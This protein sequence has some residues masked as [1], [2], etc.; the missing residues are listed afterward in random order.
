MNLFKKIFNKHHLKLMSKKG[1]YNKWH[2]FKYHK[3]THYSVLLFYLVIIVK[4]FLV[5]GIAYP[6]INPEEIKAA[7]ED[8]TT[9]TEN[10]P[11]SILT[12]T[13]NSIVRGGDGIAYVYKDYG[14]DYFGDLTHQFDSYV[15]NAN[16]TSLHV[17]WGLSNLPDG[18]ASVGLFWNVQAGDS[19][20]YLNLY[21]SSCSTMGTHE[22][23]LSSPGRRY[24]KVERSGA[25]ISVFV[26]T[27]AG[28]TS[29]EDTL[30]ANCAATTYRYL[31]AVNTS[32]GA[33]DYLDV[34]NLD[35]NP[36]TPP[37]APTIQAPEATANDA[38]SWKFTDNA[39]NEDGFRV[40]DAD[41]TLLV[42]CASA[43]LD[44]CDETGLSTNTQYTGRYVVAYNGVGESAHSGTAADTYTLANPPNNA[45]VASRTTASITWNWEVNAN[46][47]G[48]EFYASDETGNS[49]WVANATSWASA[50]ASVNTQYNLSAKARN[51]DHIDTAVIN[52]AAYTAI[53]APVSLSLSNVTQNSI[54][55]TVQ[56]S[57]SHLGVG[58]SA[59]RYCNTTTSVCSLWQT[60]TANY[61]FSS[62]LAN[63]EYNFSVE[64]RNGDGISGGTAT[65][66]TYTLI[67]APDSLTASD[68]THNSITLSVGG[69]FSNLLSGSSGLRYCNI[70][71]GGCSSWQ[72]TTANYTFSSLVADT[73][74]NFSVESR[75]FNAVSGGVATISA[76]TDANPLP[77]PPQ[78]ECKLGNISQVSVTPNVFSLSSNQTQ[79]VGV[80]FKDVHG[81]PVARD[82]VE[83]FNI[84]SD[85]DDSFWN[86]EAGGGTLSFENK[87]AL[88]IL[89]TAGN[90]PG[91]FQNTIVFS[92]C[93]GQ[94]KS[95]ATPTIIRHNS[96]RVSIDPSS[97]A[98]APFESYNFKANISASLGNENDLVCRYRWDV[99]DSTAG[100]FN[101]KIKQ[102]ISFT[103][104]D[105]IGEYKISVTVNCGGG[106]HDDDT[107]NIA[108]V[109]LDQISWRLSPAWFKLNASSGQTIA[110]KMT[111][112]VKP[113]NSNTW[114]YR[115]AKV[116]YNVLNSKA[117][118]VVNAHPTLLDT[119]YFK[120]ALPGCYPFVIKGSLAP[121][122]QVYA[123]LSLNVGSGD[124]NSSYY[125]YNPGLG[126]SILYS[127][128]LIKSSKEQTLTLQRRDKNGDF[129]SWYNWIYGSSGTDYMSTTWILND[130]RIGT[131]TSNYNSAYLNLS[132]SEVGYYKKAL[133]TI[134][135]FKGERK[136]ENWDLWIEPENGKKTYSFSSTVPK[137]VK[138]PP[139][140]LF[141]GIWQGYFTNFNEFASFGYKI[142]KINNE[143]LELASPLSASGYTGDLIFR[144]KART[145]YFKNAII[146]QSIFNSSYTKAIDVQID[147]GVEVDFCLV[148]PSPLIPLPIEPRPILPPLPDIPD[149]IGKILDFLITHP[150]ALIALML[151]AS[152]PTL[153]KSKYPFWP[154]ALSLLTAGATSNYLRIPAVASG[155]KK[156]YVFDEK[157]KKPIAKALISIFNLDSNRLVYKIRSNE[158]GE[159]ALMLPAGKFY[160]QIKRSTYRPSKIIAHTKNIFANLKLSDGYYDHLYFPE[161]ILEVFSDRRSELES[162]SIPMKKLGLTGFSFTYLLLK[163]W[164]FIKLLALPILFLG[165]TLILYALYKEPNNWLNIFVAIYYLLLWVWQVYLLGKYRKGAG[166]ILGSQGKPLDLVLVRAINLKG[167]LIATAVSDKQGRF[168]LSLPLGDYKFY[169]RKPNFKSKIVKMKIESLADLKKLKV[170]LEVER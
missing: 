136:T 102:S 143:V 164:A 94:L 154:L 107:A 39:D 74:Y 84:T 157:T 130:S 139:N 63:T 116:N 113:N 123:F 29:L 158:N 99:S 98:F 1:L 73:I 54:R 90:T 95:Y 93:E 35:L 117:G 110:L 103:A 132:K 36:D 96:L 47:A 28:R 67:E 57:F 163:L 5:L 124:H 118:S 91:T 42:E 126:D 134:I 101:T 167:E 76:K 11:G 15:D 32:A 151:L 148:T 53:E 150:L 21:G 168:I 145:G 128:H 71:S 149:I 41:D 152:V 89:F 34:R 80:I 166:L 140:F 17:I 37:A 129:Y 137:L 18:G 114:Y 156:G 121:A 125:E 51:G 22:Y 78:D 138:I 12:I 161:Q 109:N 52:L 43:D 144:S 79:T 86:L 69:S 75:N 30:S 31:S 56:G 46:P 122:P 82:D 153:L 111:P 142:K 62:L 19:H 77:P 88:Q 65:N 7:I 160:L 38:I 108:I 55:T 9:Y 23:G 100:K 50:G 165:T 97:Y 169:F 40:Y 83:N 8:Y 59:I 45:S 49:G 106:L 141:G 112:Y 87:D 2:N 26:Y 27:D 70:T 10:D 133:T 115:N 60:T 120:T 127:P 105:K 48:T 155:R 68:I 104:S 162:I 20:Y 14:I 3:I 58:L 72:K 6:V 24:F 61:T 25:S 44:H 33:A 147:S 131:M 159:F 146:L 81:N 92:A 4:L 16:P 119:S 13:P 85:Y 66:S 64:S 170:N 135:E